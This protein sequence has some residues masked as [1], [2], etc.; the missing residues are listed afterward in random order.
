MT[1]HST[2]DERPSTTTSTPTVWTQKRKETTLKPA[3]PMTTPT[4]MT[5]GT[6]QTASSI[7]GRRI[8]VGRAVPTARQT[9]TPRLNEAAANRRQHWIR[10]VSRVGPGLI[11]GASDDDP[12]GI[13]TYSQAGSQFGVG[14]LWTLLFSYPLMGGI[15]EISA[16]IGRV[17]GRGLAGNL[18]RHFPRPALYAIVSTLLAANIIN[19]AADISAMSAAMRML[20][21][22][23]PAASIVAFGAGTAALQVFVPYHRYV[24]AL[25]WLCLAL[26]GYVGIAF[27]VQIPW[28]DVARATFMPSVR[29][30]PALLTTVVAIFG[31]TISPYLFFWQASEEVEEQRLEPGEM[32]L[33]V[34]PEQS[35]DQLGRMEADTWFGMAVSNV[36]AFFVML[37]AAVVFHAR[38]ITDIQTTTQAA[39]ALRPVAGDFA[40]LLFSFG[41][42]GTGL[43]ALPVLAGSSAYA[44]GEAMLWPTG[45]EKR[46]R[47]ASGFYWLIA[48]ATTAGVGL[49]ILKFDPIRALFWSAVINGVASAP[50]MVAIMLLASRPAVMGEFTLP[51]RLRILGWSATL[52]MSVMATALLVMLKLR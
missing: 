44:V 3:R 37:T 19:I 11:T 22:G 16:R 6:A 10:L 50:I 29:W 33:K 42:I 41:I 18:R 52:V 49:N 40:H 25:K 26:F 2:S 12:S 43:L 9:R 28:G 17:T 21:G 39:E 32:P 1:R 34:A 36:V 48:I 27:A 15:Q 45:L 14:L 24:A 13:A 35:D 46:P 23:P 20:F 4:T 47:A 5:S 51:T 7:G 30:T 38:G 31:T 8:R